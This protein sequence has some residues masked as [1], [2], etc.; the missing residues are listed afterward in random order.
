MKLITLFLTA[1]VALPM[2]ADNP[3]AKNSQEGFWKPQSAT[4][5]GKPLP[6]EIL[7]I[8]TL[9]L[10]GNRYV[11]KIGSQ[12]DK[13]TW[14]LLPKTRPQAMDITGTEGPNKGKTIPTIVEVNKDTMR[15]CYGLGGKRP[16]EFKA[17]RPD[18]YLVI[19]KRQKE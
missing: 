18:L 8:L 14:K 16:K 9:R 1:S 12:V 10:E 15:V 2:L 3:K 5:G 4:L 13:G 11:V 6:A 19:Y 17:N 7:K